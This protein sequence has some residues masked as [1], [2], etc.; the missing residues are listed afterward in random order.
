MAV[1]A[2]LIN[3]KELGEEIKKWANLPKVKST[4]RDPYEAALKLVET[5]FLMPLEEIGLESKI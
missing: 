4:F 3:A 1:G 2:C 5:E